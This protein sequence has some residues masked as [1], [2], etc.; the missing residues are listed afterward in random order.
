MEWRLHSERTNKKIIEQTVTVLLRT[1]ALKSVMGFGKYREL[2]VWKILDMG[3]TRYLRHIYYQCSNISFNEEI[4]LKLKITNEWRITKPGTDK[5]MM[6]ILDEHMLLNAS[7]EG[8][9]LYG[10]SKKND[11]AG[12]KNRAETKLYTRYESAKSLQSRNHGHKR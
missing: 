4:L 1:L 9:R 6:D 12:K 11:S 5:N 7:T 10:I 2:P 3:K 8:K